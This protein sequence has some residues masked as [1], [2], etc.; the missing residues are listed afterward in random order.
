MASRLLSTTTLVTPPAYLNK[1]PAF[2]TARVGVRRG[3][4]NVKAVSNSSQ[5]AVDGTVY[6]GVY[7]PWTIDQADVKEVILYRS[8]LVTAAASFVA[9]S[10][11]AFLPGDSWLS[12]TI[13][14]NHDLFY[15]VGASG[16][17]LS[18]FLIHIYVTEIKRTLQAL[19]ALGFVGSFATYA[20]LARPA[21]DN[22]VHYVV[23]HPSAVWFVGPLF[24]SLTGLVFKEGLCYGKLE[25]GLLTFI[26]PSVLLGH[27]SGLMN[28][29]VKLVLLGT[30][31][32]LFLVF[33][34]RKFTQPIKD[35]IGDKSVFTFM[36]LSDDEKKA[37][38][39]K[40]E[41]EKLG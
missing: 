14:Q 1:S 36:S 20:A 18:L 34:G 30:W 16:L 40:L 4:A 10:S 22:L 19:W 6:K 2:L 31:M 37:I 28:D 26:I 15:F 25:A 24:A 3:R 27:L 29:E 17:G 38:V 39:E 23:D 13:K 41:Q 9:A 35:D 32:A 7:G 11:A 8:G 21:G 33:A 12:E 5:G